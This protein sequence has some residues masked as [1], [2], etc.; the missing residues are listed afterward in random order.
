[1][2]HGLGAD[3]HDLASLAAEI[4]L[5]AGARMRY[6]L[7]HAPQR[8]VTLNGGMLMPAWYDIR[9]LT[10]LNRGQ[11]ERGIKQSAASVTALIQREV[12]RGIPA[13]N[14]VLAGFSQGGAMA[15]YCGLRHAQS[16]AAIVGMS[17]YLILPESLATECSAANSATPIFLGHGSYD[18]MV[19]LQAGEMA[20]DALTALG[21]VP[22]FR[23]YPME[24]SI[25]AEEL[26]D[27][28]TF[29]ATA[30]AASKPKQEA[31]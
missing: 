25:A 5:P 20:R 17:C 27:I 8:A 7:P 24:H 10:L 11:D 16:L 23:T 4:A 21:H 22:L 15:L 30:L 1:M 2:L 29:L 19:P 13:S 26:E 28:S 14:I 12:Q 3:G 18:P 6:V 9:E 31:R